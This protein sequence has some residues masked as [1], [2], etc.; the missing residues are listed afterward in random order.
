MKDDSFQ[1]YTRWDA[2]IDAYVEI[3]FNNL[4]LKEY[5]TTAWTSQ[6]DQFTF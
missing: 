4:K 6:T 1:M 3:I 5:I 2:A